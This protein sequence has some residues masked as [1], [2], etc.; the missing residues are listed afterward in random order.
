MI[1]LYRVAGCDPCDEVQEVLRDLVVAH[2]V[3]NLEED[4]AQPPVVLEDALTTEKLPII[5]DGD[6]L[7]SGDEALRDYLAD[8]TREIE[9]WRKFQMDA[10]Y[11]DDDGEIC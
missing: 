8:L 4:Q 7:I 10:C 1:T 3:V 2:Q 11:I 6:R 9:Q 5:A